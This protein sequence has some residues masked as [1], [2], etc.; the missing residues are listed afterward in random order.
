[1]TRPQERLESIQALRGI[2][3]FG[4]LLAHLQGV[5]LHYGGGG[6]IVPRA[7]NMG[8]VGVD[9]FFLISGFVMASATQGAPRGPVGALAFLY[10]RAT[11][12]Y[13]LY[14]LATAAILGLY[15]GKARFF[16]E[17]TP[18]DNVAASLLLY[19]DD[20]FPILPV[21][22]TL[23]H[24]VYFYAIFALTLFAPRRALPVLLFFW[25]VAAALT[26]LFG[27]VSANAWTTI[28]ASPMTFEFLVGAAI[29][30]YTENRARLP[31]A[32]P[33]LMAAAAIFGA[34]IAYFSGAAYD[35]ALQPHGPRAY[36]FIAPMALFLYGAVALERRGARPP[37][38][39]VALGDASYA[40]YL[41]HLPALLV[42]GKAASLATGP[43]AF[44][45]VALFLMGLAVALGL[46]WATHRLVEKP[47]LDLT[48][49][50]G[51]RLF[52]R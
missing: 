24:E 43:G 6:E 48:R 18:T 40:L 44:D 36:Y 37:R 13:P 47:M 21:G 12:I 25:A 11:R 10:A 39:L 7:F 2:A 32:A 27:L 35:E 8:V 14:W 23:V 51:R 34:E 16:G 28:A 41:V 31:G 33:A 49:S 50:V 52:P 19:P 1:M 26:Q 5:D 20:R 42:L 29:A 38:A 45:N 30:L 3:A 9:L 4:V 46:G 22:W 17:L 15:A